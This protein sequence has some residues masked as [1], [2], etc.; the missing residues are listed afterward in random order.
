MEDFARY[1]Q[2][3]MFTL[4]N[5]AGSDN[6]FDGLYDVPFDADG[7][8]TR[9]EAGVDGDFFRQP[10]RNLRSTRPSWIGGRCALCCA[11]YRIRLTAII[12]RFAR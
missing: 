12:A 7:D 6:G 5:M 8:R 9:A 2:P 11:A 10:R 3:S 4:G 1:R